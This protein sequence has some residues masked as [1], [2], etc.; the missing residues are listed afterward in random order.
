MGWVRDHQR[1]TRLFLSNGVSL[2]LF[3]VV[4]A[5]ARRIR[6]SSPFKTYF[7]KRRPHLACQP[8]N[9]DALHS[10]TLFGSVISPI[11]DVIFFIRLVALLQKYAPG[12]NSENIIAAGTRG[13]QATFPNGDLSGALKVY[14]ESIDS[15]AIWPQ[16]LRLWVLLLLAVLVGRHTRQRTCPGAS[17]PKQI[18]LAD[19]QN[20]QSNWDLQRSETP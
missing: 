9:A 10:C 15:S 17:R 8:W 11:F 6:L 20:A 4:S 16:P 12:V 2:L 7:P 13:T 18:E 19:E 1:W 14:A 3:Y 5:L